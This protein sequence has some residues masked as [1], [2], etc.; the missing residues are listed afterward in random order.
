[1]RPFIPNLSALYASARCRFGMLLLGAAASYSAFE[2]WALEPVAK[3][4]QLQTTV[5]LDSPE[6]QAKL[7]LGA[8]QSSNPVHEESPSV[9]LA[10]ILKIK[11][12]E[13]RHG[14]LSALGDEMGK[15]NPERGWQMVLSDFTNIPDRQVFGIQVL[16]HWGQKDP[17][18]ALEACKQIPVGE[19]RALVYSAA[20]AG[21]AM[22]DPQAAA[23]WTLG[24]LSGI[25]RRT[26][27]GRIGKV[28]AQTEP[29]KAA[30][31]ALQNSFEVDQ[32]FSLNEVIDTW[33]ETY[34]RD[35]A[36]WCSKL[37]AGKLHDFALSRAVLKWADYF[38]KT[39]AEWLAE[40]PD[41]LWLLPRVAARWGQQDPLAAAVWLDKNVSEASAQEC[42][43]AMVLEW[44][45]YDPRVAFEWAVQVL[46]GAPRQ[47]AFSG[48]FSHW[49]SEYPEEARISA[50]KLADETERHTSLESIFITWGTQNLEMF[51]TWLKE[52]KPGVEKDIGIE[53]LAALLSPTNPAAALSEVLTMQNPARR[54][55]A[56]TQ[57]YQDWKLSEPLAAEAW[58]KQH[59]EAVK[60]MTP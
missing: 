1:M 6:P 27:I 11:D 43:Q 56:L 37:P 47:V 28:W 9:K 54:Q 10:S 29:H 3:S 16:R 46:K 53:Q 32:V 18:A 45:N 31:W 60:L 7:P 49:A 23:A 51:H 50:L 55:R 35:A 36:E 2:D 20:L 12:L 5:T 38:P 22:K 40:H 24:N 8:A 15:T 19:R 48:I 26:A 58:L 4:P 34:A 44:A 52:Q 17:H 42:R 41:D 30:E 39:T 59:Q 13:S 25:Y 14:L 57:H 33:A 21:W